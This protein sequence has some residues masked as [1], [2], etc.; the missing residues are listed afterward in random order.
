MESASTILITPQ[1]RNAPESTGTRALLE[2]KNDCL[3]MGPNEMRSHRALLSKANLLCKR[4]ELELAEE[5][6]QEVLV[7]FSSS[8]GPQSP[9]ALLALQSL[10]TIHLKKRDFVLAASKAQQLL[11]SSKEQHGSSHE[12][13][14]WALESLGQS[15]QAQGNLDAAESFFSKLLDRLEGLPGKGRERIDT[16]LA[17]ASIRLG[18][19]RWEDALFNH[20]EAVSWS[21]SLFGLGDDSTEKSLWALIRSYEDHQ[22][23]HVLEEQYA[24]ECR[25]HRTIFGTAD[26]DELWALQCITYIHIM[27]GRYLQASSEVE[28]LVAW[29]KD[30]YGS[31]HPVTLACR[32]HQVSLLTFSGRFKD[33]VDL[34]RGLMSDFETLYGEYSRKTLDLAI[35]LA[36]VYQDLGGF[37]DAQLLLLRAINGFERLGD[38]VKLTDSKLRLGVTMMQSDEFDAAGSYISEGLDGFDRAD[39]YVKI[40]LLGTMHIFLVNYLNFAQPDAVEILLNRIL[41]AIDYSLDLNGSAPK[42][43][44]DFVSFAASLYSAMG[45]LDKADAFFLHLIS[46]WPKIEVWNSQPEMWAV[47]TAIR[48]GCHR[49]LQ[50][51]L[52]EAELYLTIARRATMLLFGMSH[53]HLTF[54][55]RELECLGSGTTGSVAMLH[56]FGQPIIGTV[57]SAAA[58]LEVSAWKK[59]VK[60]KAREDKTLDALIRNIM[61]IAPG[62]DGRLMG[63][64]VWTRARKDDAKVE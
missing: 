48:L 57:G 45:K 53:P 62:P 60:P 2:Q 34:S 13:T 4:G 11:F 61:S 47:N 9:D 25:S 26:E 56:S 44:L 28:R 24:E 17:L 1:I 20:L 38:H 3:A 37:A 27:Q 43:V 41:G 32:T 22:K 35:N 15:H 58:D 51:D 10:V 18:Q 39:K 36:I 29:C 55:D 16:V 31:G 5:A 7:G 8:L 49:A 64:I 12:M 40:S 23:L 42:A 52:K 6:A 54:I 50:K 19:G 30:L 63:N 21:R 46:I 59:W 33:S 14:L